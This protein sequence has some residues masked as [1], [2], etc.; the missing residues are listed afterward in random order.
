MYVKYSKVEDV[1]VFIVLFYN[2]LY[3]WKVSQL[4]IGE[5]EE[6]YDRKLE[7][8]PYISVGLVH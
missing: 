8:A 6:N 5:K 3:I 4:N 7:G 2:F 1:T